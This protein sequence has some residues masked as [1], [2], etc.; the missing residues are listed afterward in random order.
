MACQGC[1]NLSDTRL[2]C[3][4]CTSFGRT[5]FFC[6][7]ECF[8]KNWAEHNKLHVILKRQQQLAN[9]AAS[10][11]SENSRGSSAPSSPKP[12]QR[13]TEFFGAPAGQ[14]SE[15]VSKAV[16]SVGSWGI[17]PLG[18][19][20]ASS[21][22]T[23]RTSGN[24][25]ETSSK[26]KSSNAAPAREAPRSMQSSATDQL[27]QHLGSFK[28]AF[29]AAAIQMREMLN[30]PKKPAGRQ[31]QPSRSGAG[32]QSVPPPAP[33]PPESLLTQW[34]AFSKSLRG[35]LWIGMGSVF[36]L[37]CVLYWQF[38]LYSSDVHYS[39]EL[40]AK[41]RMKRL[42]LEMP[43]KLN[44]A[45][46]AAAPVSAEVRKEVQ[47][48]LDSIQR[49]DKMLRYIMERFVEKDAK[50][51]QAQ[52][53][54]PEPVQKAAVSKPSGDT[55]VG[56]PV[57]ERKVSG[58]ATEYEAEKAV[59]QA[60]KS[61]EVELSSRVRAEKRKWRDEATPFAEAAEGAEMLEGDMDDPESTTHAPALKSSKRPD[62]GQEH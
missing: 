16:T 11:G 12:Q 23:S 27:E 13:S 22:S 20:P 43:Q 37:F 1:G 35:R 58:T 62:Q 59:A 7:Q 30:S 31:P 21:S 8:T 52:V 53:V 2:C 45:L 55:S 19:L 33:P 29:G 46:G 5:S 56:V 24:N 32:K 57:P 26:T 48:I 38:H 61:G 34:M 14:V 54:A 17:V 60:A 6:S 44:A 47:E 9:G 10:A 15:A 3:P 40:L 28:S 39:T 51:G 50:V 18:P 42:D 36:V 4:T 25:S 49:H 41:A